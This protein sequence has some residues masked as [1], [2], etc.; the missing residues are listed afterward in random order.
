M[1]SSRDTILEAQLAQLREIGSIERAAAEAISSLTAHTEHERAAAEKR[2]LKLR[3]GALQ[4]V[5]RKAERA[6]S[7]TQEKEVIKK[8]PEGL[9]QG[10][11]QDDS[12]LMNTPGSSRSG[13]SDQSDTPTLAED[14]QCKAQLQALQSNNA[15]LLQ[16]IDSLRAEN[17][18][19]TEKLATTAA[20]WRRRLDS[21]VEETKEKLREAK[22]EVARKEGII[23][24]ISAENTKVAVELEEQRTVLASK[25]T[26]IGKLLK[27]NQE[28]NDRLLSD[29]AIWKGKLDVLVG[30]TKERTQ[31]LR[32]KI[33]ERDALI[34][35]I[36]A[37]LKDAKAD[38][39]RIRMELL[40]GSKAVSLGVSGSR[41]PARMASSGS[42][43][44][45]T[46]M[47]K[48][49][50]LDDD[51]NEI[52]KAR[53]PAPTPNRAQFKQPASNQ[54]LPPSTPI[55]P[56]GSGLARVRFVI[57]ENK[58]PV[59]HALSSLRHADQFKA[60]FEFPILQRSV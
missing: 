23:Q 41:T 26:Q 15:V 59:A 28:L 2:I 3:D 18:E 46:T 22:A 5:E 27:T 29:E 33:L 32:D 35:K 40:T 13:Q 24:K 37:E 30:R 14:C 44:D 1:Q 6:I 60:L 39:A 51:S 20:S 7:T 21:L 16:D 43:R 52:F 4:H 58:L 48:A 19:L 34:E 8:E 12:L 17:N 25:T 31:E 11:G 53:P 45:G 54:K 55:G 36:T 10:D 57:H 50:E 49:V 38:V 56:R 42:L 47:R 9:D